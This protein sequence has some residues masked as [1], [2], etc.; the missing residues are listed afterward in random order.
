L[1]RT[2]GRKEGDKGGRKKRGRGGNNQQESH[3]QFGGKLAKSENIKKKCFH[4]A[5]LRRFHDKIKLEGA[6]DFR[7]KVKV[8]NKIIRIFGKLLIFLLP[9]FG[10]SNSYFRPTDK[11]S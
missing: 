6:Q 9:S 4:L 2:E 8:G 10:T 3:W 5:F 11:Y 1:K 7:V